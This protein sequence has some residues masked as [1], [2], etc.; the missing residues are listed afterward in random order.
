M[1]IGKVSVLC[2]AVAVLFCSVSTASLITVQDTTA[3]V[4][5]GIYTSLNNGL[6]PDSGTQFYGLSQATIA[7]YRTGVTYVQFSDLGLGATVQAGTYTLVMR[8]ASNGAQNWPGLR[9]MT[10]VGNHSGYANGFFTVVGS[11]GAGLAEDGLTTLNSMVAFNN[12]S[13]VTYTADTS[14]FAA[15]NPLP[16][17]DVAGFAQDTWYSVTS[18]WTIAVGSVV[19][20]SNPYV[21]L[22]FEIGNNNSGAVFVDDSTLTYTAI[23]EPATFGLMGVA[24]AMVIVL[25]RMRHNA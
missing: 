7:G 11:G 1:K 4:G 15:P 13:G 20:G 17:S 18:T 3:S 23:P 14:I 16:L 6:V 10:T 2:A 8:T 22:G 19:I 12:T 24:G 9:D 5:N 25:R 21:G